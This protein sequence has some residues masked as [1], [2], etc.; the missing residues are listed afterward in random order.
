MSDRWRSVAG[1]VFVTI[2]L[3]VAGGVAPEPAVAAI[4]DLIGTPL[5]LKQG[6]ADLCAPITLTVSATASRARP[7]PSC[8]VE[9][10]VC[11]STRF[12]W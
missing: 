2:I 7:S 1:V 3:V 11:L 10:S 8:G 12:C 9:R 4:G 5:S 6:G